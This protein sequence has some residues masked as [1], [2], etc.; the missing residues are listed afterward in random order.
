MAKSNQN[1]SRS[2]KAKSS[3]SEPKSARRDA[4][5]EAK[6]KRRSDAADE[7]AKIVDEPRSRA[8]IPKGAL[9]SLGVAL[10][11]IGGV[12]AFLWLRT[13]NPG[14]ALEKWAAATRQGDCEA[15]Y[16]GLSTSA[17]QAPLIGDQSNWCQLIGSTDFIGQVK[18]D[19]SSSKGSTAC[20]KATVT[21]RAGPP[22]QQVFLMVRES[23]SWK[24]DVGGDPAST[25]ISGCSVP[26]QSPP[27]GGPVAP[28]IATSPAGE[29]PSPGQGQLSP[30]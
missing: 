29:P 16:G 28:P 23:G 1:Q 8:K 19:E 17:K 26:P 2:K 30:P 24:V 9:I 6:A 10:V 11:M 22:R 18:A 27:I 12:A 20:V 14:T 4:T 5:R 3:K 15:S 21:D 7:A 25:G 13:E